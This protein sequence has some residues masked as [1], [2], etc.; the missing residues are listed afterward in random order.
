MTDDTQDPHANHLPPPVAKDPAAVSL[1]RRGGRAG[2]GASKRR[3]RKH[4]QA[5]GKAG[6]LSRWGNREPGEPHPPPK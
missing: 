6:M 3:T 1:G 4:C 5:A 2:T